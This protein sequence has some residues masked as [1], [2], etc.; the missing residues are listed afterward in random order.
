MK[1][2]AKSLLAFSVAAVVSG[3]AAAGDKTVHVYN[4][5]DYIAPDTVANFEK[6]SGIK[7]VYDVFDANET[8]EAKLLTGSS[9]YDVVVPSNQ[10]L[11]KQ[12]KAGVFLKLDKSKLPNWKNLDVELLKKLEVSDPGNQYSIPYMWGTTGIGYNPD[13]VKA[14]LGIDKID[15]WDVLFKPENISKLKECGVSMLDAPQEVLAAALHYQGLNPNPK[16][17]K[18]LAKAEE[19]MMKVRPYISYFHSSKFISDLAN[20]NICVALGWSGDII[21]AKNRADEAKNGVKVAYAIPK[22]GAAAFFDMLAV[23]ADTKNA[24]NAYA[25]LNYI[26]EPKVAAD[27]SNF[28]NYPSG[29][30]EATQ[31]V[32]PEIRDNPEIYPPADVRAKLYVFSELSPKVQRAMTRTW[33]KIKSGK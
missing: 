23:P 30:S 22:E 25:F 17:P 5:S 3:V 31:Y 15:S 11:A 1:M 12:I 19:L 32:N 16:D 4:W 2:I 29:N 13:K 20:G 7:V 18:E 26:M 8:L 24:D 28:V 27:I 21:Q 10:F 33:T 9:G 6:A 14:V